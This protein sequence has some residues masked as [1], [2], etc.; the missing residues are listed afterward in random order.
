LFLTAQ[1]MDRHWRVDLQH[2]HDLSLAIDPQGP[3]PRFFCV[4]HASARPLQSGSF[5]GSIDR[6]GAVNADILEIIPHC[7]GTHTESVAHVTAGSASAYATAGGSD[8]HNTH[9]QSGTATPSLLSAVLISLPATAADQTDE[10]YHLG[11]LAEEPV[12]TRA[13]LLQNEQQTAWL[14]HAD[15][16]IIRSLPN[17]ASK[18]SRNYSELPWY[19]VLSEDAIKHLTSLR[20]S[21]LLIDTPSLDRADDGGRV[22]NH[23]TWWGVHADGSID[24]PQRLLTEMIYA[25]D[26][27]ADG[28][29]LLDMQIAPLVTDAVPSRPVIYPLSALTP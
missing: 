23:K 11:A 15:A 19:P 28:L 20:L 21:H 26:G 4:D 9:A 12:L 18:R 5:I 6:G 22:Y 3:H 1:F 8:G 27:I 16:V 14:E 13:D 2:G 17:P 25:H 10:R 29:Y 24:H 7:Q